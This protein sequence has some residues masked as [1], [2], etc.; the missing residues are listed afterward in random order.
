MEVCITHCAGRFS[1]RPPTK[2]PIPQVSDWVG[3][4]RTPVGDYTAPA[5][6]SSV[7]AVGSSPTLRVTWTI[8]AMQVRDELLKSLQSAKVCLADPSPSETGHK[9][10]TER[11]PRKHQ[12]QAIHA[13]VWLGDSML[14]GDDMGIGK[15]STVLWCL[16]QSGA[17]RALV[18]CPVSVKFN[19]KSEFTLTLGSKWATHVIDGSSNQRAQQFV[20]AMSFEPIIGP[21]GYDQDQDPRSPE[22][23]AIIINYDLLRHL[24]PRQ[25]N[26]LQRFVAG[27]ALICDES[28]YLKSRNAERTKLVRDLAHDA[29]HRFLMT[30]TPVRNLVDDLFSQ[31]SLVRPQIWSSYRD[32]AR[33]YL[34]ERPVTF[35][36]KTVTRVVGSRNV[37]ELNAV[38]NTVMIRR[39]KSE[40]DS[41]PPKVHTYPE[42]TL[43]AT[44]R[45]IYNAMADFARVELKALT[46]DAPVS[47]FDPRAKSAIEAAMRCEQIAQGFIGG[48]PQPV[49]DRLDAKVLREAEKVKG[50]PHE[51]IF[52]QAPKLTW[53]LEAIDSVLKQGGAPLVF[54]RFNAPM[55]W[56]QGVLSAKGINAA[57]L[58]GS[59]SATEK[60]EVVTGFRDRR[61]D[62]LIAQVKIAE[63]WNATRS[64]DV[65]FLGRDW[66]HAINNQAEDRTHRDGQTGTVNVQIPV[67]RQTIE[68]MHHRRLQAKAENADQALRDLTAQQIMEG[69]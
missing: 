58:H 22:Y 11:R 65:L 12:L 21:P 42:I 29:G 36:K 19:W 51:L 31:I 61:F 33:R 53:L 52:P 28:H 35:G 67:V 34:V 38:L 62:V 15:T 59:L 14:L 66:S 44:T 6:V 49:M 8:D 47:V 13:C 10:P 27:Q 30:G 55:G 7:L 17:T 37:E 69:L 54:T 26:Q 46:S 63:G 2:K 50:R 32:F 57:C 48:I 25:L 60:H 9:W 39:K 68:V 56:L 64:R 16:Q 40:V 1:I 20:E 4:R 18:V 24:T 3:W 45:K 5:Y 41:L 23:L 43:D